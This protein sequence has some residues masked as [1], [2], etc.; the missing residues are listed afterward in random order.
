MFG[1]YSAYSEK[2]QRFLSK[3]VDHTWDPGLAL[4]KLH[5]KRIGREVNE[6][7]TSEAM[8]NIP[9]KGKRGWD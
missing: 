1:L 7:V 4:R 3:R 8:L 9:G 6:H 5:V 2:P